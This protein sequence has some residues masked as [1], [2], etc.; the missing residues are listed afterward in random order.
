VISQLGWL[1]GRRVFVFVYILASRPRGTLY[2]GVTSDIIRRVHDHKSHAVPG[3]TSR[4]GVDR[5][6]WFE[7]HMS[8]REAIARE[9]QIKEWR[10]L[11]DRVDRGCQPAL[12]RSLS[13]A[14]FLN[15]VAAKI[16]GRHPD[17]SRD[18]SRH[19]H[20]C[21]AGPLTPLAT[22]A[23][24]APFGGRGEGRWRRQRCTWRGDPERWRSRV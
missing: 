14:L 7:T 5:L 16:Q 18:P 10:R 11:E 21:V 23:M 4:Y 6:A 8:A 1:A 19:P 3:F 13:L 22:A 24:V 12:G 17:E 20:G 2:T 9:K 15:G